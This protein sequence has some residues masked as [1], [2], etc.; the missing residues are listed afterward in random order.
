MAV[1]SSRNRFR[2]KVA[3]SSDH[4]YLS[5][6]S[7]F[8]PWRC[9][10][11]ENYSVFYALYVVFLLQLILGINNTLYLLSLVQPNSDEPL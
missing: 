8:L 6:T 3:G 9:M 4:A 7:E 2:P 1:F 10:Y 11:N 5:Y